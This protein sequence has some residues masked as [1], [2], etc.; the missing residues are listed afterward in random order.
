M[1]RQIF[2]AG[3]SVRFQE[4][5]SGISSWT[6]RTAASTVRVIPPSSWMLSIRGRCGWAG[7]FR[8]CSVAA[9]PQ[10]RQV[11][12]F[13]QV[14]GVGPLAAEPDDDVGGHVGMVGEPGQHPLEDLVVEPL[15]RQS[16]APLVRDRE[17][18]VDVGKVGSPAAVAEP[19][20]DV[21]RG[22]GRAVDGADHRDVVPRAHP[23]VGAEIALKRPRPIGRGHRRPLGGEGV[24]A[25]EQVGLEVVDVNVRTRPESACEANPMIWPYFRTGSPWAMS[26]SATLCPSAIG[27]RTS[28]ERFPRVRRN[29][30]GIGRAATATLSSPR[31]RT[32]LGG[33]VAVAI[34]RPFEA[35][36][37]FQVRSSTS[38]SLVA[39]TAR[40]EVALSRALP[41]R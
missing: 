8:P 5:A 25:L 14:L 1:A 3:C 39:R 17:D 37:S 36:Q 13:D 12:G 34:A 33:S 32:A 20:G 22:A 38:V 19:V 23:A 27:S 4:L 26:R 18:A 6:A 15:E 28:T 41:S 16:A 30:L 40:W 9:G 24:V 29:P 2:E 7:W 10:Q 35:I 21:P 11:L 31:S